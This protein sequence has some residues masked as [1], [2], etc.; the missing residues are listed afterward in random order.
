[1][2]RS[3][4]REGPGSYNGFSNEDRYVM[5][6]WFMKQTKR[7]RSG[8]PS[9][10]PPLEQCGLCGQ[11]RGI[12]EHHTEDYNFPWGRHS[13]EWVLCYRC[14]MVLHCQRSAPAAWTDYLGVISAGWMF[15]PINAPRNAGWGIIVSQHLAAGMRRCRRG[16]DETLR[17]EFSDGLIWRGPFDSTLEAM[18]AA[19]RAARLRRDELGPVAQQLA[20][21][22]MDVMMRR[23]HQ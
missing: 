8:L 16:A 1:M 12:L 21:S 14:H 6:P 2:A 19:G 15:P 9:E 13:G 4:S 5:M 20:R 3:T 17:V 22:G 23:T 10:L 18:L 7:V 11:E